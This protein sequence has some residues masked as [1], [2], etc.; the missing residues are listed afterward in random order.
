MPHWFFVAAMTLY[1]LLFGSFANVVIWRVPRG[2]SIV[3]P[4]S[5]CPACEAPIAWF[6]NIP[7]VSW[8][9]LR[10]RCRSCASRISPR[11]PLVEAASGALFL[12]AALRFGVSWRAVV[13]AIVFWLLLVLSAIDLDVLRLPN[14]LVLAL[15]SVGGIATLVSE[16]TGVQIVPL[17]AEQGSAILGRPLLSALVGVALGVGLTA[18]IAIVYRTVRHRR[19]LGMGDVKLLGALGLLLG[20]YVVMAMFFGSLFGMAAGLTSGHAV[21]ASERP[22]PFGPWLA[23]GAVVTILA[24]SYIWEWYGRV[25]GLI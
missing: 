2:E 17:P 19:G 5:H 16:L 8:L 15:A 25:A 11:Y 13:T 23:A 3:R 7:V 24:G 20:P 1:G 10:G 9:V 4:G 18:T 22:M 14:P 6:D 12:A 21:R